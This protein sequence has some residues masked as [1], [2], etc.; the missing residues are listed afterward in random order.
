MNSSLY[1]VPMESTPFPGA[2]S[3]KD[4]RNAVRKRFN[5]RVKIV[6]DGVLVTGK[7]HDVSLTG[8]SVILPELLP[9]G[10]KLVQAHV[11]VFHQGKNYI[12]EVPAAPVYSVLMG[13]DGY[14]MGLQFGSVPDQSKKVLGNLMEA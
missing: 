12:F 2:Q 1:S 14:K 5:G 4:L 13:T 3:G 7:L 9:S 10:R 11:D 6:S 8:A